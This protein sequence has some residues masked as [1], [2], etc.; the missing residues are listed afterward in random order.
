MMHSPHSLRRCKLIG[1]VSPAVR[2]DCYNA[3][4]AAAGARSEEILEEYHKLLSTKQ[5]MRQKAKD[6]KAQFKKAT[7]KLIGLVSAYV[8]EFSFINLLSCSHYVDEQP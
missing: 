8:D 7:A 6:Q 4:K 1:E 3:F 2:K 5:G